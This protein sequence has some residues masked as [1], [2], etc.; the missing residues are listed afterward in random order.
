M[1][2]STDPSFARSR[3]DP[4]E[5]AS[6]GVQSQGRDVWGGEGLDEAPPGWLV[7]WA[8]WETPLFAYEGVSRELFF[9]DVIVF[10]PS[11][12]S[13]RSESL[14][15]ADPLACLYHLSFIAL[16]TFYLFH[17]AFLLYFTS[18]KFALTCLLTLHKKKRFSSVCFIASLIHSFRYSSFL[19]YPFDFLLS[20]LVQ[21]ESRL[22]TKQASP[23][24]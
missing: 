16:H 23:H 21:H 17:P 22:G 5:G 7:F 3:L 20:L 18:V 11:V 24:T 6:S 12:C 19:L 13:F 15:L 8:I 10:Y 14:R 1:E 2:N 9:S 4:P